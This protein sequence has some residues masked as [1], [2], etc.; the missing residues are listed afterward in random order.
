MRVVG[1]PT[2]ER[3]SGKQFKCCTNPAKPRNQTFNS[4]RV[5]VKLHFIVTICVLQQ[6]LDK[7]E[8]ID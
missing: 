6:V 3:E 1:L 5:Q 4:I 7:L 2:T 8:I